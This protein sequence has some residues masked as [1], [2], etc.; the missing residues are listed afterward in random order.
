M[1]DA[2]SLPLPREVKEKVQRSVPLLSV[3]GLEAHPLILCR[4]ASSHHECG[5]KACRASQGSTGDLP[6]LIVASQ[7]KVVRKGGD[8][9]RHVV[10]VT[11][12]AQ[13][14]VLK[15]MMSRGGTRVREGSKRK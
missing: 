12:N 4:V 10:K 8:Q 15:V 14:D 11:V 7:Q 2:E 3:N 13:G 9:L 1:T 6:E 5:G